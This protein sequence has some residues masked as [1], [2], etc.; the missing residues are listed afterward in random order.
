[1]DWRHYP[2]LSRRRNLPAH[3]LRVLPECREIR[4]QSS[5]RGAQPYFDP[6]MV[7]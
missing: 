2:E 4:W 7:H 1:M 5:E 6:D 3:P